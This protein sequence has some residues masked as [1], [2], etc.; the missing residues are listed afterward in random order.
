MKRNVREP[1]GHF[2]ID[3]KEWSF[4]LIETDN[5]G[6]AEFCDLPADFRTNR[7]SR[8]SYHH[9][10]STD[11][12]SN[13]AQIKLHRLPAEKV[14]HGDLSNLFPQ[15]CILEQLSQ[16]RHHLVLDLGICRELEDPYHLRS[17]SGRNRNEYFLDPAS[18]HPG[19]ESLS[20]SQHTLSEKDQIGLLRI[21]VNEPDDTAH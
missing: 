14:F 15:I 9:H 17:S 19:P 6:W 16:T 20:R 8:A 12:L 18:L 5:S 21:V 1:F 3:V 2:P 10:S 11:A 4:S 7:S 13:Q